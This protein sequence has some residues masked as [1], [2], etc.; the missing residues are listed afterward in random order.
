MK[1]SYILLA[2][3]LLVI[4]YSSPISAKQN[5]VAVMPFNNG[6]LGWNGL[7]KEHILKGITQMITD[8]LVEV[9]GIKVV[10]RTR[11]NKLIKEQKLGQS[12]LID[13]V[14]AAELGRILGVDALILGTLTQMEI[15]EKASISFGPFKSSGVAAKVLLSGRLVD[16]SSGEIKSSFQGIGEGSDRSIQIS[17]L[18]GVSFGTEAFKKSA[19][20][21]SIEQATDDFINNIT[22]GLKSKSIEGKVVK[23]LSNKVIIKVESSEDFALGQRGQLLRLIEVEELEEAV[24]MP[25]GEVRVISLSK[26]AVIAE[27]IEAD[28]QVTKGD[29]I[30][31]E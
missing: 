23:V 14:T 30:K 4:V 25:M 21:K 9:D 8:K 3:I 7:D 1:K 15:K 27:I 13:S 19:L 26:G 22:E 6:D 31:F 24:T 16:A 20:G 12:G 10:E 18:K 11:L 29:I 28:S 5:L 2:L 17:N